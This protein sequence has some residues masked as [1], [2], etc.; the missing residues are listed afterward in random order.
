M[1]FTSVP[2]R[3]TLALIAAVGAACGAFGAAALSA[4]GATPPATAA[5]S[6]GNAALACVRPTDALALDQILSRAGSPLAGLGATFV[7]AGADAG[8]DPRFLVAIAAQET[9]LET[10][11][12]AQTINNPFGLGPGLAF[13]NPSDAIADAARTLAADYLARGLT[14]IPQISAKWAPLG[15]ANDPSDLNANWTTDVSQYYR[16]LGG[17]PDAPVLLSDQSGACDGTASAAHS[18][19]APLPLI[20]VKPLGPAHYTVIQGPAQP[21]GTHDPKFNLL[22]GSYNWQSIWAVDLG[23]PIGTPVYASFSG[24]IVTVHSG[25]S[26]RFAGISVG[27]DS[28]RG[29]AAYYAHLSATDV[30]PGESVVAGQVIGR[31]GEADGVA[32]LHF[33]LGRSY[34]DGNPS[35]GLNPL[36]FLAEASPTATLAELRIA[37]AHTL[38]AGSGRPVVTVWGGNAPTTLAP[39][40]TGG[41]DPAT[42]RPATIASFAFPVAVRAGG[43]VRYLPPLCAAGAP[44]VVGI[45]T[46]VGADAVA[47]TAGTLE[48]ATATQRHAGIAF[49]IDSAGG[50]RI[51]YGPL[52]SYDAGIVPGATVHVGEPLGTSAGTLPVAWQRGST[53]INPWPLLTA[54]RPSN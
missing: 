45:A 11:G 32:H 3:R 2:M 49:W 28:G 37:S 48:P 47:A 33:A 15:A 36:P 29:L 4:A 50:N 52:S 23:V 53:A 6:Q 35:N 22:H 9:M 18:A 12:P 8:I 51:G 34:A 38:A 24:T 19:T 7:S 54:V 16:T 25:Q 1:R 26:G 17:D 46:P 10:Y 39:G 21:G 13:A 43:Q 27:L 42:G 41:N 30:R 5:P 31:T 14:A 44:C 20:T 40:P